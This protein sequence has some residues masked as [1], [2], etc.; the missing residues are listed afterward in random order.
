VKAEPQERIGAAG[1]EG[2][3]QGVLKQFVGMAEDARIQRLWDRLADT[4]LSSKWHG[5]KVC[6]RVLL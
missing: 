6:V 1:S 5:H 3:K 2:G 4:G